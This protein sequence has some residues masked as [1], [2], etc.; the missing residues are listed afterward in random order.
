M[1]TCP[2]S[3]SEGAA[4]RSEAEG[5]SSDGSSG[6]MVYPQAIIVSEI[7]SGYEHQRAGGNLPHNVNHPPAGCFASGRVIFAGSAWGICFAIHRGAR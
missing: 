7:L 2:G 3:L 4:E 6:P 5:V 1:G